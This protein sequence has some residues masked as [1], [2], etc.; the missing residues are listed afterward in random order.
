[1]PKKEHYVP[2]FLLRSF[3]I[4][5]DDQIYVFDKLTERVFKSNIGNVAS[6][7]RFYDIVVKDYVFSLE[8]S[9]SDLE[10]DASE[11]IRKI[12][13]F[14][15]INRISEDEKIKLSSFIAI[16]I[17]RGK[18]ARQNLIDASK[19]LEQRLGEMGIDPKDVVNFE[20]LDEE[21]AK[22]NAMLMVSNYQELV[23]Y[24]YNKWWL[25]LKTPKMRPFYISD[26]PVVMQNLFDHSPRGNLGLAVKGIEVYLPLSKTLTLGLYCRSHEVYI[27]ESVKKLNLIKK[28][29]KDFVPQNKKSYDVLMRLWN[30]LQSGSAIQ[31]TE[32]N[33]LNLNSLQVG[34]SYRFTFSS[35]E[36][37]KFSLSDNP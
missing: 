20:P 19:L 32:T 23:P 16:Q 6:E 27:R 31:I 15:N 10:S 2:K 13:Y 17:Q 22:L 34:Y 1:L 18:Q 29:D 33:L 14:Q 26:N 5:K 21:G 4:N 12:I 36:D 3:A 35:K 11:I 28:H 8:P 30:G 9:L 25:L 37:F 24:I 7:K